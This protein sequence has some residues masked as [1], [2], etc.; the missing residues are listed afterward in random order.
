MVFDLGNR[1]KRYLHDFTVRA[2]HF[3]ARSRECLSSLHAANGAPH[4]LAINRYNLNIG[5]AVQRLQGREGFSY[6]HV[7][8]SSEVHPS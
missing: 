4:A 2:F 8:I 3:D 6:F 7:T 1:R 5:F